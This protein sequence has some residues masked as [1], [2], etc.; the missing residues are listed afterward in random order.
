MNLNS[1]TTKDTKE[2]ILLVANRDPTSLPPIM[3]RPRFRVKCRGDEKSSW[4]YLPVG[5]ERFTGR[6]RPSR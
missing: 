1:G 4:I 6:K 5:G 2:E 3:S